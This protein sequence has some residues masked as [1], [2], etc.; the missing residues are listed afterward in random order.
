MDGELTIVPVSPDEAYGPTYHE[1]K[2][3]NIPEFGDEIYLDSSLPSYPP[4]QVKVVE[5][6]VYGGGAVCLAQ[7]NGSQVLCKTRHDGLRDC[8]LRREIDCHPRS[9]AIL[10][11]LREWVASKDNLKHLK[12]AGFPDFPKETRQKIG[13]QKKGECRNPPRNASHLG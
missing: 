3:Q 4:E 7:V 12:E 6:L 1:E 9:S 8:N 11:F 2:K 13:R 10:G 5:Q